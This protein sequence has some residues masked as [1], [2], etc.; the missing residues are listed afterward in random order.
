M[1]LAATVVGQMD[2][3]EHM[4]GWGGGWMWLFG[5]AMMV[6]LVIVVIWLVRTSTGSA[7]RSTPDPT[8]RAREVL[9][10]RFATGEV[11]KEE[12]RDRLA[13]LQRRDG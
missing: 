4:D 3:G 10:E 9:A 8:V 7:T 5:V 11:S 6:L 1:Y 13:E 12:Y 2:G